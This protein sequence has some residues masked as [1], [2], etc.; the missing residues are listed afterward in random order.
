MVDTKLDE[1]KKRVIDKV[2]KKVMKEYKS[3]MIKLG[4]G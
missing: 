4:D 3:T 1:K 2:Y